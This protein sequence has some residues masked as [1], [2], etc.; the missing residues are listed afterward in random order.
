MSYKND[1]KEFLSTLQEFR[2]NIERIEYLSVGADKWEYFV[3]AH[4]KRPETT[5]T[6]EPTEK[7]IKQQQRFRRNKARFGAS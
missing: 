6:E 3:L 7:E 1:V 2:L 4:E 5:D